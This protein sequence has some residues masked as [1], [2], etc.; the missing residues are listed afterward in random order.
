MSEPPALPRDQCKIDAE[1][2]HLLAAFH[3]VGAGLASLGLLFLFGHYAIF[4]SIMDNPKLWE[5]QKGG[6]PPVEFFQVFRWFYLIGG[7]WLVAS[8]VINVI[9]GIFLRARKHRMFSLIVA[10]LNC[11]HIPLGTVLGVFT[12]VVLM[13]DSVRESYDA[14]E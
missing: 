8:G 5:G 12:L 6:P 9:S 13:R 1:H 10:G 11:V 7:A 3:F 14:L 4:H 2:I